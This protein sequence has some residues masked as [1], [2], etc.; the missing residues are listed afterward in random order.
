MIRILSQTSCA[1]LQNFEDEMIDGE[2]LLDLSDKELMMLE[3]NDDE[4]QRLRVEIADLP[5]RRMLPEATAVPRAP[6]AVIQRYDPTKTKKSEASYRFAS[7]NMVN[8]NPAL[9]R[10]DKNK[11][12]AQTGAPMTPEQAM[13]ASKAKKK[14]KKFADDSKLKV[15]APML[16][17]R[18]LKERLAK[19]RAEEKLRQVSARAPDDKRA[20]H[21]RK[22]A[23]EQVRREV[24]NQRKTRARKLKV[25][26]KKD[27]FQMGQM[28]GD[29]PPVRHFVSMHLHVLLFMV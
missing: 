4:I 12:I 5:N 6:K 10:K 1:C 2:A 7:L 27:V 3:L 25:I 8:L 15:Q 20:L 13:A 24:V 21:V 14:M 22:E 11:H 29:L 19:E 26:K 28:Y 9:A 16:A 23:D 18:R 17:E